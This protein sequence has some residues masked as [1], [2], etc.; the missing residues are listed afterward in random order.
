MTCRCRSVGTTMRTPS[1]ASASSISAIPG[2]TGAPTAGTARR[3]CSDTS[4]MAVTATRFDPASARRWVR[5]IRPA[6]MSPS[7]NGGAMSQPP[8]GEEGPVEVLLP[9][10]AREP[11]RAA[12]QDVLLHHQPATEGHAAQA[13]K[14]GIHVE[15]TVAEGA[16][17]LAGPDLG[18]LRPVGLDPVAD[19]QRGVLEVHVVDAL[20]PVPEH[21]HR[22][23]PAEHHVPGLQA[24]P[25]IGAVEYLLDLPGG[26]HVG[27]GLRVERGL[28]ATVAAAADHP[29]QARGEPA[30][31]VTVEAQRALRGRPERQTAALPAPGV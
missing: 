28:V 11:F 20:S 13:V 2:Y 21:G 18:R 4:A 1:R 3:T 15:V 8:R 6:P 24:Q 7:R 23:A 19:R 16:E 12:R 26:L 14:H 17:R 31:A 30:P 22:V 9:R 29:G 25:D 5:P 10:G 27:P